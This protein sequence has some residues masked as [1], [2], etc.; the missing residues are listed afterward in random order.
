[1]KTII[2]NRAVCENCHVVLESVEENDE[3]TC[4]CENLVISGGRNYFRIQRF[5]NNVCCD[6]IF[7]E[8]QFY[9]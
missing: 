5:I 7:L 2:A 3:Q 9:T 6:G 8:T 4:I 1:M